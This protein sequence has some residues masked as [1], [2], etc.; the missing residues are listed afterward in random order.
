M[1]IVWE[2]L[3]KRLEGLPPKTIFFVDNPLDIEGFRWAPRSFLAGDTLPSVTDDEDNPYAERQFF[4]SYLDLTHR[5]LRFLRQDPTVRLA[6]LVS[7]ER[8]GLRVCFSGYRLHVQMSMHTELQ[9]MF[10]SNKS[11][12]L[13]IL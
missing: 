12:I 11:F 6:E 9:A 10:P 1:A 5:S 3:A 2:L 13:G 8:K 7:G 4:D